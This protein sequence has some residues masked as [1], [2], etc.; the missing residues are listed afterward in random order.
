MRKFKFENIEEFDSVYEIF[1]LLAEDKRGYIIKD[2][3]EEVFKDNGLE[4]PLKEVFYTKS[5]KGVIRAIHFQSVKPQAKLV[6]CISGK[7]FDVIVDLRI[8]SPTY[9]KWKGFFLDESSQELYIPHGFGHGY[10]VL[11]DSIVSYK[12]D[13]KFYGEYD[14]GICW[15]D[16]DINIKW[17]LEEVSELILSDKDK[18]L[19]T[20]QEYEIN[21]NVFKMNIDKGIM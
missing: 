8:D 2:Y 7:I 10:L 11:E 15:D 6:R 16:K 12:C 17:P 13:E 3:H 5:K 9:K 18:N 1:P 21:K 4:L 14:T 19:Q 20:L